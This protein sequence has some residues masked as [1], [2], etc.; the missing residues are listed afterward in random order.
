MTSEV[1]ILTK[2]FGILA[3]D[4]QQTMADGKT[5][6]GIKKI[7]ELS[8]LHSAGIMINC[9][10]DFEEVPIETLISEFKLKTDFRRIGT[11]EGIKNELINFLAENT[12]NS[13]TD[14]YLEKTLKS[15]KMI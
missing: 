11:I 10:P 5:Y 14:E 7:F 13:S 2:R 12:E 1:V 15:L 6:G 9:N 3:A 8:K 4:R